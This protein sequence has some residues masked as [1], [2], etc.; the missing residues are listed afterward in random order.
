MTEEA[1]T[2]PGSQAFRNTIGGEKH[3]IKKSSL[4]ISASNTCIF[5]SLS[6]R[7]GGGE[8]GRKENLKW[9]VLIGSAHQKRALSQLFQLLERHSTPTPAVL[10]PP[11]N[12]DV[13]ILCLHFRKLPGEAPFLAPGRNQLMNGMEVRIPRPG[14]LEAVGR[15]LSSEG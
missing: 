7:G 3:S 8:K 1:A 5:S 4:V 10:P 6:G 14:K 11:M 15:E 13:I 2:A 12:Y 9:H